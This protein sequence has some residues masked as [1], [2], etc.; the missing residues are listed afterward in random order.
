MIRWQCIFNDQTGPRAQPAGQG[1]VCA[2]PHRE[3]HPGRGVC[4]G[5]C[6]LPAP[7]RSH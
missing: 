1:P 7:Q 2:G 6:W 4:W 3:R 5:V